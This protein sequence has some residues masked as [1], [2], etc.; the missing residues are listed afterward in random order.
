MD[1]EEILKNVKYK[2]INRE[3]NKELLKRVPHMD[4]LDLS[5][6]Y[7]ITHFVRG[8]K[9]TR[10]ISNKD[11]EMEGLEMRE[12]DRSARENTE[13]EGFVMGEIQDILAE[14]TGE[15]LPAMMEGKVYV[16]TS[17]GMK[18]GAAVMLYKECFKALADM[19]GSDLYILPSRIHEV[20]VM[21]A[22]L[23]N[24]GELGKVVRGVNDAIVEGGDFLSNNVYRY[25][26]KTGEI[27]VEIQGKS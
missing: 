24:A 4:V 18:Y 10:I 2:L 12:L 21:P 16:L 22:L 11:M 26:Q 20:I 23:L 14:Y 25:S 1:K 27:T 9:Y 19:K 13:R 7:R 5:A 3:E 15:A 8:R 17:K 6:V